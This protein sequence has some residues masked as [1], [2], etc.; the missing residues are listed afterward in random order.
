VLYTTLNQESQARK[1]WRVAV[2]GGVPQEIRLPLDRLGPIG[3]VSLHPDGKQI[4]F[5][6][7]PPPTQTVWAL[8]NFLPRR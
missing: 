7:Q 6:S 2:D 4:A 3:W 8:D 5:V 1:V